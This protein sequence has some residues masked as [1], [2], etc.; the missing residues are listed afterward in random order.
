[1]IL[2]VLETASRDGSEQKLKLHMQ[3]LC[4]C[5]WTV[6]FRIINYDNSKI[7]AIMLSLYIIL[8]TVHIFC[9]KWHKQEAHLEYSL[10]KV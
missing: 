4:S 10:V 2:P 8:K 6:Y 1:M 5:A 9:R 3:V 7:T